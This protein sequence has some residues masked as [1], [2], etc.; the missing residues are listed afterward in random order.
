M[1]WCCPV[2]YFNSRFPATQGYAFVLGKPWVLFCAFRLEIDMNEATQSH[3][4]ESRNVPEPPEAT[5]HCLHMSP[6]L[7]VAK[8][9][10]E[11]CGLWPAV[12]T[13][14]WKRSRSILAHPRPS[15]PIP[16]TAMESHLQPWRCSIS[17]D[18]G[19]PGAGETR[20]DRRSIFDHSAC[21][22][23]TVSVLGSV[24]SLRRHGSTNARLC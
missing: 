10:V 20:R 18:S 14:G 11:T 21:P 19:F 7:A 3:K 24:S 15:P 22:Y 12:A 13:Y 17:F 6:R 23:Q 16:W 4:K 5:C 2:C 8:L 1:A 9:P